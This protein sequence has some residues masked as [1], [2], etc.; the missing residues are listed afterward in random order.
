MEDNMYFSL[1][2]SSYPKS[3]NP[4]S[5]FIYNGFFDPFTPNPMRNAIEV[6]LTNI[7]V[8][9]TQRIYSLYANCPDQLQIF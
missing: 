5:P 4:A 6:T 2:H 8:T 1:V 7:S 3:T 9:S